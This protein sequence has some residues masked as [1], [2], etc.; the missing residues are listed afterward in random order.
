MNHNQ[1]FPIN[2]TIYLTK[3]DR[4]TYSVYTLHILHPTHQILNTL[5][6]QS[7]AVHSYKV[8]QQYARQEYSQVGIGNVGH[9]VYNPV[10][11]GRSGGELP[12]TYRGQGGRGK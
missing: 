6:H 12:S 3:Y 9:G 2:F 7:H 1:D 4:D 10:M 8:T 11:Y 5:S